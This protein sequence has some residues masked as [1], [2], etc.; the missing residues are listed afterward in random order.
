MQVLRL[1]PLCRSNPGPAC[2]PGGDLTQYCP[3][4]NPA[5][6]PPHS[7]SA[8]G[9]N[10]SG[11]NVGLGGSAGGARDVTSGN[12]L[13]PG[14]SDWEPA[15]CEAAARAKSAQRMARR[16]SDGRRDMSAASVVV[17]RRE[18]KRGGDPLQ[19]SASEP[20]HE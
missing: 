13:K 8:M 9:P 11:L 12:S 10:F 17:A 4:L 5:A 2:I 3:P 15:A 14:G 19:K 1:R 6:S 7:M 16:E 18:G 20:E